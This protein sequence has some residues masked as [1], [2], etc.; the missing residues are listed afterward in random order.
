MQRAFLYP[1]REFPP[2]RRTNSPSPKIFPI[3]QKQIINSCH[4][5]FGRARPTG[6]PFHHPQ[7][8]FQFNESK[9]L[10]LVTGRSGGEPASVNDFCFEKLSSGG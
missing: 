9:L 4:R 2:D 3:Q 1:E 7:K 8:Y 5:S 6:G 10:T